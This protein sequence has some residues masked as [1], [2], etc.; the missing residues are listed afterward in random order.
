MEILLKHQNQ[1]MAALTGS[2]MKISLG[3]KK[4]IF[5]QNDSASNTGIQS[6]IVRHGGEKAANAIL[7]KSFGGLMRT[8]AIT[9]AVI[10]S[11]DLTKNL[12]LLAAGKISKS[13]FEERS[14]KSIINT[15]AGVYG[16]AIGATI[17]TPF[18]PPVGTYVGS[19]LGAMVSGFAMQFV[20][21]NGIEKEFRETVEDTAQVKEAMATFQAAAGNIFNGQVMFE[22]YL[23]LEAQLDVQLQEVGTR[24]ETAGVDMKSAIDRL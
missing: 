22:H 14:G 16:G 21:E 24:L 20:I 7:L 4:Y 18:F 17:G 5:K 1:M 2:S 8:S 12:V 23:Q 11:I 13:E 3:L 6:M 9:V 19:V 10:G 15:G